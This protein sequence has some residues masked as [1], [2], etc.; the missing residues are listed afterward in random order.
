MVGL[1]HACVSFP[2]DMRVT[3]DPRNQNVILIW[4]TMRMLCSY[5]SFGDLS[6][7]WNLSVQLNSQPHLSQGGWWIWISSP[8]KISSVLYRCCHRGSIYGGNLTL[9]QTTV[10]RGWLI[11]WIRC[12][13]S[14][15]GCILSCVGSGI[16]ICLIAIWG[17][18]NL[19]VFI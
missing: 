8:I 7:H 3:V 9:R 6:R 1:K 19:I 10:C 11:G 15:A 4:W 18:R 2:R 17:R 5:F 14:V 16:S 13:R 12:K